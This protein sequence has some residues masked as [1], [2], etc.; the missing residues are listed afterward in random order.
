MQRQRLARL[1]REGWPEG[2]L[3]RGCVLIELLA[4]STEEVA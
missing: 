4:K 2:A 1:A 3:A